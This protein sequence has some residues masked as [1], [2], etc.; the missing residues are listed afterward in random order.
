MTPDR[1]L[2]TAL[3]LSVPVNAIGAAAF[4]LLAVG[5]SSPLLPVSPSPFLAGYV[6]FVVAVFGGVYYWLARQ[7]VIHRP[8]VV[9]GALSKLGFVLCTV[10]YALAGVVPALMILSTLPDLV[11]GSAFLWLVRITSGYSD[12]ASRSSLRDRQ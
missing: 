5:H 2:R 11:L 8:I 12:A 1:L 3:R 4:A 6:A 10:A 7:P 9:I